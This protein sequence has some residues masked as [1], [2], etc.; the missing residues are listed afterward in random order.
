MTHSIDI[1]NIQIK[2]I[3]VYK[4]RIWHSWRTVEPVK[5]RGV[6]SRTVKTMRCMLKC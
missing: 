1:I 4:G 6:L 5:W 2:T 3:L